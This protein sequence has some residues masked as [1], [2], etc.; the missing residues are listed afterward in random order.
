MII[1]TPVTLLFW[2]LNIIIY[3]SQS[4]EGVYLF[5]GRILKVFILFHSER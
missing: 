1:V 3:V 2:I 5:V 4:H